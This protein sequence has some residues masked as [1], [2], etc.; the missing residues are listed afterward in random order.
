[1]V[2]FTGYEDT[3]GIKLVLVYN[4]NDLLCGAMGCKLCQA[5]SAKMLA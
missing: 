5:G 4:T 3:I 2:I 1:M